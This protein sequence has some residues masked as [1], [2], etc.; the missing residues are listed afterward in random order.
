[1]PVPF[2]YFL[3]GTYTALPTKGYIEVTMPNKSI[4][5]KNTPKKTNSLRAQARWGQVPLFVV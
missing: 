1:M 5:D 2:L 3:L 4:F